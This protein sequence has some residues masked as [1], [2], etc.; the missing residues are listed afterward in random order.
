M[1]KMHNEINDASKPLLKVLF[2]RKLYTRSHL[3]Y[4]FSLNSRYR[5]P[6]VL[7]NKE[8]STY[9]YYRILHY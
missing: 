7:Q 8:E 9:K 2:P 6:E 5:K 3:K 1:K 4:Y